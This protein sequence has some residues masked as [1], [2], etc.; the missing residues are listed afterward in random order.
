MGAR[1]ERHGDHQLHVRH[2]R[3][4]QGRADDPPQH[5]GRRDDVRLAHGGQRPRRLPAHAADVPLQRLGDAVHDGRHGRARRSCC[6]RSTARRSCGGW[7]GTASRSCAPRRPSWQRCWT[8]LRTGT[9]R[10]PVAAGSASW[11][12]GPR[13]R[14][15]RSCGSRRSSA[16]SSSRSTASPRPRRCSPS[17]GRG[18]SGT[19]CSAEERAAKLVRAGSPAVG[20]R[21]EVDAEGEVLARSNVVLAGYW[22]N[23]EETERLPRGRLVPH[24]RRRRHRRRRLPH[25]PGPQEGRHHHRRRER[26]VDRGRGRHLQPPRRR[27]GGG[28]RRPRREVGRDDQGAGRARPRARR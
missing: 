20:V 26:V 18:R 21:L 6:A 22:K 23:P 2:D 19:T 14:P 1:R 7:S 16:G 24:R 28:H 4:A 17:T 13:R 8:P 9:A 10:S 15:G 11:W 25:H 12:P 3:P 5:L 27:R